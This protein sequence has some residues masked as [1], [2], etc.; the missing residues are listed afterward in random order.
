[1]F[2]LE[3]KVREW[4]EKWMVK[5]VVTQYVEDSGIAGI[6]ISEKS[7]RMTDLKLL[8]KI[9]ECKVHSI[10]IDVFTNS[11]EIWLEVK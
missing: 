5:Y 4:A 2:N 3:E 6:T 9:T 8:E 1:M 7:I 10:D 11:L